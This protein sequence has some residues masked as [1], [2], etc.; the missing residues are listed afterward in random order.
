MSIERTLFS[1]CHTLA[2]LSMP[3]A[4]NFRPSQLQATWVMDCCDGNRMS[5]GLN[6]EN[7]GAYEE[8]MRPSSLESI[9]EQRGLGIHTCSPRA[10]NVVCGG[11]DGGRSGGG[12]SSSSFEVEFA[13]W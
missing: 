11:G 6:A 3:T 13:I 5:R 12:I 10:A 8:E 1:G 7:V 2:T 9:E 4:P